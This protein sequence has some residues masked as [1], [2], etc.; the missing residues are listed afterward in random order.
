MREHPWLE[1][2]YRA[3][4]RPEKPRIGMCPW[5]GEPLHPG[6]RCS[7]DDAKDYAPSTTTREL[8]K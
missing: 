2:W 1:P 5:C 4:S 6:R 7:N 8:N 3:L